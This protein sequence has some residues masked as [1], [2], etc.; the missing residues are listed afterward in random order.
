[1]CDACHMIKLIRNLFGD[2]KIIKDQDGNVIH[3][4]HIS[5]L[6]NIQQ[7]E[8]LNL[9]NKISKRHIQY[10]QQKMK[11]KFAV[12][13]LSATVGN[14]LLFLSQETSGVPGG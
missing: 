6:E 3:C 2:V 5:L 9:A 12:Q 14:A 4:N 8:C 13:V 7:N 1:M 10:K 11:V